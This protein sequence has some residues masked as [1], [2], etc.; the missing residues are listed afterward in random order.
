MSVASSTVTSTPARGGPALA[1]PLEALTAQGTADPRTRT[2]TVASACCRG[3]SA[4]LVASRA[5]TVSAA[6]IAADWPS[7]ATTTLELH[8]P[9][10]LRATASM[11]RSAP[12]ARRTR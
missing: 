7:S 8:K 2:R 5:S 3:I 9:G 1:V 12:T 11:A 4:R 6:V 10:L